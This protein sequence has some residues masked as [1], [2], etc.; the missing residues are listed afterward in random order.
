MKK[1]LITC[2]VCASAI[3]LNACDNTNDK[4]TSNS[5]TS[6]LN[7]AQVQKI[8]AKY[9]DENPKALIASLEKYQE[10][11][12]KEEQEKAKSAVK[13]NRDAMLNLKYSAAF[14]ELDSKN[15]V[16]EFFDY[17]CGYCKRAAPT[18][19]R[20]IDDQDDLKVVFIELP[21]LGPSSEL[22]AAAALVVQ[23]KRPEKYREFHNAMMAHNGA[24]DLSVINQIARDLDIRDISFAVEVKDPEIIAAIEAN[25]VIADK[26]GIRGTPAFVINDE[27]V[28]GAVPYEQIVEVIKETSAK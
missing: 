15:Y 16:V 21:V 23:Q 4:A 10:Q 2:L 11:A 1:I 5:G 17:N 6:G 26:L 14:G 12:M 22:A 8:V 19:D 9:I 27:L 18:V 13:D 24:K 25:R 3:A 7:E 20:L 28:P